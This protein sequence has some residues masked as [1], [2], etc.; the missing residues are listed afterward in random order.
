MP[1]E[2]KT[3]VKGLS[4]SGVTEDGN[5]VQVDVKNGKIIRIRPFHFDWK[6]DRKPW[7]FKARGQVF[8]ATMK[9]LIPP[10]TLAYKNRVHSPNRTMYPLKRV[11]W[12]PNGERN[13]QN[14]GKSRYQR[15][16]WDEATDIIASE[17][18]RIIKKYGPTAILAQGD[19]H[20][21]TKVIHAA[22][23]CMRK[24][25]R[26]LGGY[27]YQTRNPDSWEG[28]YWGAK[29]VWGC[30]P[31][32]KQVSQS[33]L[34]P[35]IAENAE[36][37]IYQGSDPETTPWGWGGQI[38]SRL[39]YWFTELG[40]KH[41]YIC[42]DLN[43]GAAVHADKWIPIIPNTDAA[44]QLAIAYIW[45]TE[46]TYDQ[47]YVAT[48]VV[49]FDRFEKYVL[50]KEDGIAKTPTWASAKTGIPSRIIKALA[51]AWASRTTSTVHANGGN[52]ARGPYAHENMRLEVCLLGMQGLGK[53]GRHMLST[54]EWGLFGVWI[55]PPKWGFGEAIP[56]P[57]HSA[58]PDLVAANRGGFSE[59]EL[60]QQ[61]LPK[62]L[63]HKAIL[64]PPLTWYGTTLCRFLVEDQ[65]VQYKYPNDGC[66]ELHMIWTDTPALMSCWNDSNYTAKA[67]QS[68]KI[69]F[70]LAQHPWVENDCEF[71][72]IILPV[73]TKFENDDIGVDNFTAE[74]GTLYLDQ[75]CVE[76]RGESKSDYGAVCAIAEKLGLLEQYTD[77]KS[78][79]DWIRVGYEQSG[80]KDMV[81]WEEFKEKGH[82]VIPNDPDWDK[83][84]I[85]MRQFYE[86]PENNPLQT[87]TGK[88]EFYSQRLA[89]HFPGDEERSPIPRWIEKGE[90]H[91]ERLSSQRARK[92]P[93][94]VTSNHPRWRVHSQHDDMQWLREMQT[95]KIVGPDGYAYQTMWLHPEEAEKKGIRH[96]DVVKIFNERGGVLAGAYVTERI[97]PGVVYIDHGARYDPIVPGEL[98][99]GGAINTI[100]PRNTQ[101]RNATGMVSGGFL[102]NVE[103]VNLDEL[104]KK[105]PEAFNRPY[106]RSSGLCYER[107]LYGGES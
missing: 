106:H 77:G 8:R 55:D 43:Y 35:D 48:H 17:I 42:P 80:L 64:E 93:Y 13:P 9:S 81:S 91:D 38:V 102:V 19:G 10:F 44:L 41:V 88:L 1:E 95:C 69:E 105:Y 57:R 31:V 33:N 26:L 12:D 66:S 56:V 22:H 5:V 39:C 75:K 90:S 37:L 67:Y 47:D 61:F 14:R 62:P 103:R 28:W 70:M 29:H 53:P 36:M 98:D 30:E 45:I 85:G 21:E 79:D 94:L 92:Y 71:A 89:D 87:P 84:E 11:D 63:I 83:N 23:G 99:R 25:L 2:V 101:S 27:T 72:D 34:I 58:Y 97:M 60:P 50:G 78:V 54:I 51:R 68:P 107:M 18:K 96:G 104:R 32:G 4:F 16:S 65:F 100:T 86:D 46:G 59:P 49:G 6:Y 20:G 82:Y 76:P 74:F 15:I 52:M 3:F 7:E 40:I 24:L 73:T